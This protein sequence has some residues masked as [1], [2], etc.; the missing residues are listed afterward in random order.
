[1]II[2]I[3]LWLRVVIGLWLTIQLLLL[4]TLLLMPL[5]ADYRLMLGAAMVMVSLPFSLLGMLV[6]ALG[7]DTL[8]AVSERLWCFVA[9]AL[10]FSAGAAEFWALMAVIRWMRRVRSKNPTP[11]IP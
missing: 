6:A 4:A 10:C 9:W 3:P 2:A 1:M 5:N 8:A 7:W 11:T